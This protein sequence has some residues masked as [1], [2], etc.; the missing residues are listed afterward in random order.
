MCREIVIEPSVACRKLWTE[1]SMIA[2]G[3]MRGITP[4]SL[5]AQA[6]PSKDLPIGKENV[7]L[8]HPE[9]P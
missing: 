3:L 8:A 9:R 4:C 5:D 7:E 1:T 2:F 6:L